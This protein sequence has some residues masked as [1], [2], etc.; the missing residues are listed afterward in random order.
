MKKIIPLS[1]LLIAAFLASAMGQTDDLAFEIRGEGALQG[2]PVLL[3]LKT[4][5]PALWATAVWQG[6]KLRFDPSGEMLIALAA[7]DRN[8]KPGVYPLVIKVIFEDGKKESFSRSVTV[9]SKNFETQ[10]LK[11]DPRFVKLSKEDLARV[12]DDNKATGKA[13]ASSGPERLWQSNFLKPAEARWSGSFGVRRMF[14]GQER[15]Y[16]SG[17]DIA[18]PTGTEIKASNNGRVAL[19]KDM[20]FGGKT[21]ILDHGQGVFTGYMHLSQFKVAEGQLVE[22]GEVIALSGMTGRVTGPHLHWMLRVNSLKVNPQGL[23]KMEVE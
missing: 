3:T 9:D 13:Y 21:V 10:K 1:L 19:V 12:A 23:L 7:I 20:F 14:N 15:S 11:V 22:K 16:H 8:C 6:Q 18:V 4:A 2:E 17:A 5:R